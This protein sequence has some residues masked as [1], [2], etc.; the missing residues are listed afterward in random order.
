M[1]ACRHYQ[2]TIYC[3]TTTVYA[4][5]SL[6]A[7]Y[8]TQE[9]LGLHSVAT[10]LSIFSRFMVYAL[11]YNRNAV[12]PVQFLLFIHSTVTISVA[13][14]RFCRQRPFRAEVPIL[15]FP[16]V[17]VYMRDRR[18]VLEFRESLKT[19]PFPFHSINESE[20]KKLL[21]RPK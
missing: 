5:L 9:I 6:S 20:T 10:V 2:I 17:A 11:F 1:A 15:H 14:I 12:S 7:P 16:K 19:V 4:S 8:F 21:E 13:F 18:T 3:L